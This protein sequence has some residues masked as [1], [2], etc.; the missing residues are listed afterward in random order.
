EHHVTRGNDD[1][2]DDFMIRPGQSWCVISSAVEG[3]THVTVYCPEIYNWDSNKVVVTTHWVDV[4]WSLPRPVVAR[5]GSEAVLN[6]GVIRVSDRQ[7][8]AGYKVRYRVLD[9]PPAVF[10]PGR[11]AEHVAT[12]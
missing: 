3:D 11:T 1:P 12:S 5:S 10:L 8:L 6:T 7:P 4:G 2:N 9:G